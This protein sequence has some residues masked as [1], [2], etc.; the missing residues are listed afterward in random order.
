MHMHL[1]HIIIIRVSQII[2]FQYWPPKIAWFTSTT[3][4]CNFSLK[5]P[6]TKSYKLCHTCSLHVDACIWVWSEF[7]SQNPFK[8]H[9]IKVYSLGVYVC[10]A[11]YIQTVN[12]HFRWDWKGEKWSILKMSLFDRWILQEYRLHAKHHLQKR[13]EK[14]NLQLIRFQPQTG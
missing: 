1:K 10:L 8:L 9:I 3:D 4:R 13:K 6:C 2:Q 5:K 12:W 11:F 14:S 7:L